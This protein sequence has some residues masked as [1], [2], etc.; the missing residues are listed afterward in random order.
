M[1]VIEINKQHM[2]QAAET[3]A[4]SFK[5]DPIFRYIFKTKEA[6][7]KNAKW[8]F[9]TWV[10]WSVMFG[11]AWMTEDGNAVVLFRALGNADMSLWSMIRAGML[12]TPFRLGFAAFR[13]F[14]FEI[15]STLDRKH[16]E[17][18]GK[19]PHWYGWMIGVN[20]EHRG[21][22]RHLMKHCAEIADE[23]QLPVFLETATDVNV[24]IYDYKGFEI[25]AKVTIAEGNFTLYFMVRQP[26]KKTEE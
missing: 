23:A 25:K 4:L 14:Y 9:S 16:T 11:K 8:L 26:Q 6:Y 2:D 3:L 7:N 18:M 12:P 13:R 21:I 17:V 19:T 22:G 5:D 1:K 24:S 10:R 20:P 15:V